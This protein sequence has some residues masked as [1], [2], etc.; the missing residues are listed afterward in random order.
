MYIITGAKNVQ[1][2]FGSPNT[3]DG[4]FL[5]LAIM[6]PIWALSREELARFANDK[7]GRLKT[8]APEA[9]GTP[10]SE[11][12]WFG[13]TD[14]YVKYLTPMESSDALA[15]RFYRLFTKRLYKE[16][17]ADNWITVQLFD[18]LKNTMVESATISLF[19]S[20]IIDMNPGFVKC[21]WEF[22]EIAATLIWG[23][24]KWLRPDPYRR[25]ERLLQMTIKH[26][27]SAWERFDWDGPE[28]DTS[29]DPHFGCRLSRETAKWMREK[30]FSNRAAAGHVLSTIFG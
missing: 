3:L 9:E 20:R 21:Y 26:I 24:P 14:L 1:K 5:Q 13:H 18:L 12:Y 25:H 4:N 7:T 2:V 17:P 16:A 6:K 22:D 29:W 15:E 8:P 27:E 23:L 10:A 30:G 28:A 11:R 19:G